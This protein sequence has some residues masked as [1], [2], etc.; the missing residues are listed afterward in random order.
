[1]VSIILWL[2]TQAS[3]PFIANGFSTP[4]HFLLQLNMSQEL[5]D[6]RTIKIKNEPDCSLTTR[7]TEATDRHALSHV[8]NGN[9]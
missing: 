4:V 9:L 8:C 2:D 1:V 6:E 7:S 3:K 5:K